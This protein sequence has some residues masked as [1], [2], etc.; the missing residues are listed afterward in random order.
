MREGDPFLTAELDE[1]RAN[2]RR[3][4]RALPLPTPRPVPGVSRPTDHEAALV[5]TVLRKRLQRALD[6][7][8]IRPLVERSLE[9]LG[10]REVL[11]FLDDVHSLGW[12]NE[13]VPLIQEFGGM[14]EE[15]GSLFQGVAQ[16]AWEITYLAAF[17]D[18]CA[19]DYNGHWLVHVFPGSGA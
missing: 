18:L 13:L 9:G 8:A 7:D 12:R 10:K 17:A 15:S 1:L 11:I 2:Q 6:S 3:I 4:V 19:G 16:Q 5:E 14:P